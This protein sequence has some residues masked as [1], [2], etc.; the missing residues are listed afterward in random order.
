MAG[1]GG[2]CLELEGGFSALLPAVGGGGVSEE[3]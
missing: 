1:V 3:L 2:V